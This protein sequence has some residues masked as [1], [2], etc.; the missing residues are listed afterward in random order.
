MRPSSARGH[1]YE[2]L[3]RRRSVAT[4]IEKMT[5]IPVPTSCDFSFRSALKDGVLLCRLMNRLSPFSVPKVVDNN[6]LDANVEGGVINCANLDNFLLAAEK[7]GMPPEN[8][9]SI[10]DVFEGTWEDR[11]KVAECLYQLE[12]I[13]EQMGLPDDPAAS[14]LSGEAAFSSFGSGGLSVGSPD[15]FEQYSLTNGMQESLRKQLQNLM[16]G[17][18]GKILEGQGITGFDTLMEECSSILRGRMSHDGV[19][20]PNSTPNAPATGVLSPFG[21]PPP[22]GDSGALK[23]LESMLKQVLDGITNAQ[24]QNNRTSNEQMK[25]YISSLEQQIEL[26]QSQPPAYDSGYV[27]EEME[28]VQRTAEELTYKLDEYEKTNMVLESELESEKREKARLA[29]QLDEL[30]NQVDSAT[31]LNTKY[32]EIQEENRK[33]YNLVQ[34]LRGNIRVFCR[35]RPMGITGDDTECCVDVDD[36]SEVAIQNNKGNDKR[37]IFNFDKVFCM[38]SQQDAVYAETQPLIRSVLDGYNVC[39]FAY[40]QTGSGKTHTMNGTNVVEYEGR[41]INYRALDDLFQ[42]KRDRADEV[43]YNIRVQMVEIYNEVLRDLL[44]REHTKKNRLDIM[45]T[46]K[47]GENVPDATQMCVSCT[48]DVLSFMEIGAKNRAVGSTKMNQRSSRSHSVLTVIVDGNNRVTGVRTH[49]CLHLVDLAGSERVARSEA[50]GD[51]LEEAKHINKSLSALGDVMSALAQKSSHV[52][53]RNSKLTQLLQ[54]SL[55]G[56]AKAMM[57][58]HIAPEASSRGET[59]STLMFGARVSQVTLGQARQN[60][61][62]SKIYEARDAIKRHQLTAEKRQERIEELERAVQTERAEREAM[63]KRLLSLQEELQN[64]RRSLAS[65]ASETPSVDSTRDHHRNAGHSTDCSPP[66]SR[67]T[68]L[69]R[70]GSTDTSNQRPS[71]ARTRPSGEAA[72]REPSSRASLSQRSGGMSARSRASESGSTS[73][74]QGNHTRSI[75]AINSRSGGLR[76]TVGDRSARRT[77][78]DSAR[79]GDRSI[80]GS[81]ASGLLKKSHSANG[82]ISSRSSATENVKQKS[83]LSISTRKAA[84]L[85]TSSIS[86]GSSG[87]SA[88]GSAR[89]TGG[90][91]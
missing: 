50:S 24:E 1:D 26:L 77:P 76:N 44:T 7:F 9:F 83:N 88:R 18:E 17:M 58:M 57:F 33:L 23:S 22:S 63:E 56:Q 15:P 82:R 5:G 75:S 16:P 41:G 62:S 73:F 28:A 30:R 42:I 69:Q 39:I 47:S 20:S 80:S 32:R 45:S 11:P 90:W 46:E 12:R 48:E 89:G 91:R 2:S 81:K 8:L 13:A 3:A 38:S 61:E 64:T 70:F 21:A 19:V 36:N 52:P 59:L 10:D 79:N 40:G 4:W 29:A 31:N 55:S 25:K 37:K 51:R 43:D 84:P 68:R 34:D 49:A 54:D 6:D 60:T 66:S 27:P 53:Y 35:V 74:R 87:L 14:A 85:R 86:N 65:C 67:G 71:S 72:R 78:Q